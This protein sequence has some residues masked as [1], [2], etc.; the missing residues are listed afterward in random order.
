[1]EGGTKPDEAGWRVDYL[2]YSE[3]LDLAR[4]WIQLVFVTITK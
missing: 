3:A 2:A 1:M 4:R